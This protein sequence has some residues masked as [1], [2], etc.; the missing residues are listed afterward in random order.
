MAVKKVKYK[1]DH[2]GTDHDPGEGK[3]D[4]NCPLSQI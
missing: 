2:Y 4:D 3:L 1:S